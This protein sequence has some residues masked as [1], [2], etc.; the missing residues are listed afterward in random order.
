MGA[1]APPELAYNYLKNMLSEIVWCM[2]SNVISDVSKID[3]TADDV[4][5]P[6]HMRWST[7][8]I[9]DNVDSQH[10]VADGQRDLADNC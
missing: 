6:E 7:V 1:R 9:V 8:D 10:R 2:S 5:F 4:D 3:D